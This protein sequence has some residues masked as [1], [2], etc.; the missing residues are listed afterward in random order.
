MRSYFHWLQPSRQQEQFS[1][2]LVEIRAKG[3]TSNVTETEMMN[4]HELNNLLGID[5]I[6]RYDEKYKGML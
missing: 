3:T 6:Y 1:D 5:D 4:Y 2:I